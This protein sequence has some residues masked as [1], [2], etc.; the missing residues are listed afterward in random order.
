[1]KKKQTHNE[2]KK[3]QNIQK[4]LRKKAEK[5]QFA[6]KRAEQI[7]KWQKAKAEAKAERIK[8]RK[9]KREQSIK[10]KADNTVVGKIKNYFK[11]GDK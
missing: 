10:A 9:A 1:M 5:E 3:K 2:W 7:A 4:V 6:L 8:A 11:S